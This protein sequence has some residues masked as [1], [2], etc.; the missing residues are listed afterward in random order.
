M[1]RR[2]GR[3]AANDPGL[4]RPAECQ[5]RRR[6]AWSARPGTSMST[7]RSASRCDE[8]LDDDRAR[9]SSHAKTRMAE[10]MFDAEHFFDGYKANPAYA[11]RMR[12][13]GLQRRRALDRAVRHQR[14]HAAARDRAHRRR[15]GARRSR[16]T[17]SASIA[18]TTPRTRSPIRWPRCAPAR[19]RCRAR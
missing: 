8:N 3:S 15:R 16:A 11:L 19:G 2:P 13:G 17:I 5:G 1:T 6:S 18:T 7:S 10:V 14:R 9:A 4:D 12:R